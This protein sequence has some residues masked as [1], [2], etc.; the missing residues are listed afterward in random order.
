[1]I[2]PISTFYLSPC[3]ANPATESPDFRGLQLLVPIY[4]LLV[5]SL[6]KTG[7]FHIIFLSSTNNLLI[8]FASF[9]TEPPEGPY[10]MSR[11]GVASKFNLSNG[12]SDGFIQKP[13]DVRI[14][15][16]KIKQLLPEALG[17]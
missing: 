6:T 14:M 15:S 10:S 4:R 8:H 7:I 9:I 5:L 13:F 3:Q 2:L 16:I 1:M 11:N 12:S 17:G